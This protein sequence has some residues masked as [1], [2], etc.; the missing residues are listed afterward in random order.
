MTPFR[1]SAGT[2]PARTAITAVLATLVAAGGLA[3]AGT[4]QAGPLRASA[5]LTTDPLGVVNATANSGSAY[6][7]YPLAT[8]VASATATRRHLVVEA[9]AAGNSPSFG[10]KYG[11]SADVSTAYA[12]WNLA[13][14]RAL[15]DLE[16]A[17]LR[18]SFNFNLSGSTTASGDSHERAVGFSGGLNYSAFPF[19]VGFGGNASVSQD[20]FGRVEVGDQTLVSSLVDIDYAL[21]HAGAAGGTVAFSIFT[22]ASIGATTYYDLWLE[23]VT[24]IETVASAGARFAPLMSTSFMAASASASAYDL[25][26]GLGVKLLDDTGE[27]IVVRAT[28]NPPGG[29]QVPAPP[30]LALA[31]VALV[32]MRAGRCGARATA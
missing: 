4:A 14:N 32:L 25:A 22:I 26:N 16:A 3:A 9:N 10:D 8:P 27:I 1:T 31:L 12:L 20:P 18:L 7:A 13:E 5:S 29:G 24:L 28:A 21:E 2:A 19:A 30:T 23:S 17:S 11:A 6:A 15:T